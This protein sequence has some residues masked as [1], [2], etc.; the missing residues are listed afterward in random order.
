MRPV[1]P[2]VLALAGALGGCSFGDCAFETAVAETT[3][4]LLV[5]DGRAVTDTLTVAVVLGPD[6]LVDLSVE[7]GAVEAGTTP[8]RAV[9]VL[10][11]ARATAH[12][13]DPAP[14]PLAAA[15]VGDTVFVYVVGAFDPSLVERACSPPPAE[16]V[17]VRIREVLVPAGTV[18]ARVVGLDAT[19][20]TRSQAAAVRAAGAA[21]RA[22]RTSPI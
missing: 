11:D 8:D 15:A 10:Y 2:L 12:S 19:T 6:P 4:G 22:A 21:R 1:V 7:P 17:E 18:E 9:E 5:A 14:R 13:G 20:L 3:G 16:T